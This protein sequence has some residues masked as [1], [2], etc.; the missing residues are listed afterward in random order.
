MK[1]DELTS[2]ITDVTKVYREIDDTPRRGKTKARR[3][4]PKN[5]RPNLDR[6]AAIT[7]QFK[8]ITGIRLR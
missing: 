1:S 3:T 8:R 5:A 4:L 7:T 6:T 2:S